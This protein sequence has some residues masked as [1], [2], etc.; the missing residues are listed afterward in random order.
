MTAAACGMRDPKRV[1]DGCC[2][3]G[4]GGHQNV[5]CDGL[6]LRSPRLLP[7]L[8]LRL[9]S[10]LATVPCPPFVV[11]NP[12]RVRRFC[13]TSWLQERFILALVPTLMSIL[14]LSI[15][16]IGCRPRPGNTLG[17]DHYDIPITHTH[18][19]PPLGWNPASNSE[20]GRSFGGAHLTPP[21]LLR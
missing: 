3:G 11:R 19:T 5:L 10:S 7:P 18:E 9:D 1:W 4:K 17:N 13:T 16:A 2:L 6:T 14:S 20:G 12:T 15:N 21:P 8:N